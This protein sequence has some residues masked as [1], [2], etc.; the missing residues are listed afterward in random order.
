MRIAEWNYFGPRSTPHEVRDLRKASFQYHQTLGMPIVHK[1]KWNEI[2]VREGRAQHCPFHD[3]AYDE[4]NIDCPYCFGTNFL[5]GWDNGAITYI[6]IADAATDTIKQTEQGVL[7][8]DT[9]PT[10]TAPWVPTMGDEDII[11]TADFDSQTWD[12]IVERERYVLREVTARTMRGFQAKV[13]TREYKVHQEGAI[14]KLPLTDYRYK[15]PIIFDYGAVP[16]PPVVPPGG[17]P[18]DYP[19]GYSTT[20]FN[21][22]VRVTGGEY[23]QTS[24]MSQDVRVFGGGTNSAVA[25]GVRITGKD[26]GSVVIFDNE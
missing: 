11:I 20:S 2:D 16:L 13:Q 15:V 24:V 14:D 19:S 6:T 1:H 25:Y 26:P 3:I 12:I 18:D 22:G 4:S 8:I 5:G 7:Y 9:H 10:F 21:I 23:G 17:D